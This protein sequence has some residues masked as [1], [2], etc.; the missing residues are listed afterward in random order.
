VRG[1]PRINASLPDLEK[2]KRMLARVLRKRDYAEPVAAWRAAPE[3]ALNLLDPTEKAAW[4]EA[5]LPLMRSGRTIDNRRLR[6][7]Y[8]LFAFMK[9]AAD[10]RHAVLETLHTRLRLE[11]PSLPVFSDP[12]VR[13]ALM[14]EAVAMAGRSPSSEA[15][16]YVQ[17][18]RDHLKVKASEE[19]RWG[20]FFERLTDAENRVAAM[21]GKRGHIVA[22]DDRKLEIFKKAVAAIGVP[23]ALIF[24]LGTVGLTVEGITSGLIALGGGFVLPAGAAMVAGVGVVVAIGVSSKKI[25]DM[26]WPTTGADKTSIDIQRLNADAERI[27]VLLDEAVADEAKLTSARA[28]ITRIVNQMLPLSEP[29]RA[30]MKAAFE[31]VQALGRRYLDYLTEDREHLERSNQLGADELCALLNLDTPAIA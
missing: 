17:R 5:L 4:I 18:L 7:L 13:R 2:G 23:A 24:P 30:K 6:R 10:Q 1:L 25:L 26:I 22:M 27:Q 20:P 11:P 19:T 29:E 12:Q 8:Q 9:M 28:E 31:H 3:T 21:L 16:A 14:T 15:Q